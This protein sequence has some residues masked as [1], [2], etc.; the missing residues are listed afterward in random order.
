VP[1]SARKGLASIEPPSV[2]W[3]TSGPFAWSTNGPSGVDAVALP[4]Q[5]FAV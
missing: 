2:R 5:R 4:T 1:S 3:Q